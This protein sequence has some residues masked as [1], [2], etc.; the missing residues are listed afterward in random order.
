MK[1]AIHLYERANWTRGPDPSS[2]SGADRTYDL[3]L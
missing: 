1:A 3:I 2:G